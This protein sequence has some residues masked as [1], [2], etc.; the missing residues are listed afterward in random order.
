LKFAHFLVFWVAFFTSWVNPEELLKE[1]DRIYNYYVDELKLVEKGNSIT[2]SFKALVFIIDGDGGTAFG[3][4]ED[5]KVGIFWAPP[6]RMQ[7]KPFGAL[8][9]ELTHSFQYLLKADG[10]TTFTA[11][12]AIYEMSAQYCLWQVYPEWMTFEN[13][14]LVDFMKQTHYS[15][16]HEI[17]MY[18]SPYVLEYWADK[19]GKEFFGKFWREVGDGEDAVMGYKRLTGIGQE[20]FNNEIFDAAQR[21]ITWDMKRIQEVAKPY[22]NQHTCKLDS[23]EDGWFRIAESRCPQNYGYNGIKLKVPGKGKV[24]NVQFKGIAGAGGFNAVNVDK[25]GWRYGFVACKKNGKRVY[26]DMHAEANGEAAFKVPNNAEYLWLVVTGAPTE[27]W[28]H[29]R[30]RRGEEG[31]DEQ[32]PYEI[33]LSGTSLYESVL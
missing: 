11:G 14:H 2:D 27:H 29:K 23:V 10:A 8:V 26:G 7:K 3:G 31:N 19:H 25:A 5:D 1:G 21:F 30:S 4:G 20:T 18:H 22:R 16:L 13:Y 6:S 9:H 17:N 12:H 33:K 32:W 15:F 24:V 28:I